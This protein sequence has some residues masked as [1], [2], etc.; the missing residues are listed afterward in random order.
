MSEQPGPSRPGRID[1][2]VAG[3]GAF[4][5][6]IIVSLIALLPEGHYLRDL[7]TRLSPAITAT[8]IWVV[9]KLRDRWVEGTEDNYISATALQEKKM[10]LDKLNDP[11]LSDEA[12]VE[13][14]KGIEDIN[15]LEIE[16]AISKV[17]RAR[18]MIERRRTADKR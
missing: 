9:V 4:V 15:L 7:L 8:A 18:A 17:R 14:V 13:V 1:S 6:T 10:L 5:G 12:K 16:M 3:G 11:T 2:A